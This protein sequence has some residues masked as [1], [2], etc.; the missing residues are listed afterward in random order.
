[1]R[2]CMR[3]CEKVFII[4]P[5]EVSSGNGFTPIRGAGLPRSGVGGTM[6]ALMKKLMGIFLLLTGAL[7]GLHAQPAGPSPLVNPRAA[8]RTVPGG[9]IVAEGRAADALE[10]GFSATAASIYR[11]LLVTPDL[12]TETRR[13]TTLAL[14]SALMESGELTEAEKILQSYDGPR[15]A[16]YQLRAGL[17]A[18]N[19]RRIPQAK[20][21]LAAGRA[22]DLVAADRGWWYFLQ[23]LVAEAEG[24]FTRRDRAY[25]EANKAAVSDL[26]RV[27]FQISQEATLLR[28]GPATE[29]MLASMRSNMEKFPGQRTGYDA[30]RHYAAALA[31]LNRKSE[32]L[33][34]LQRQ[35]AALPFTERGVA[36]QTRLMI[37]LIAG[38]GTPSGSKALNE[39]VAGGSRPETQRIALALLAR[40]A[41]T[42]A[43]REQLRRDLSELIGG[44]LAHPI[45]EDLRLARAQAA[46][47]DQ[48]YAPAEEDARTL[49]E[50]FPGSPLKAAALGVRLTVAWELKR[51]R[52]AADVIVQLRTALQ[53]GRE[54][55]ELGV[56]LAE[57]FFR[58]E[59]YKNAA[60]TYDAALRE[61]PQV[62]PAGVLIFQRVLSDIR[63]G[64]LDAAASLLD[65]T[66]SNATFDATNRWQ[67]EWNLVKEMQVRG[68]TS[69]AYARVNRLLGSGAQGV[70]DEL[71]VRLMWLRARLSF[72]SGEPDATHRQVDELLAL[73]LDGAKNLETGLRSDIAG[74]A[75]LL[76]AQALLA[77]NRDQEGATLL[78][79]LRADYKGTKAAIYSYIVQAGGLTQ[80]G[81]IVKAQELL[82]KLVDEHTQT[83]FAPLALYQLA[84]NSERLGLDRNLRDA[85]TF[86]ERL[87]RD[88]PRDDLVFHARLKQGDL[89]RKLNDF[90]AART[91]YESLVNNFA[92]HPDV[93]LAHLALADTLFAQGA[94]SVVN[95]ESAA[96]IFERLRDLPSATVD[97][98]AEAGFKWGYALAKRAQASS[99][100]T[101]RE[102]QT[103]KAQVVY[104]SVI[105][106]FLQDR[107]QAAKLG[108]KGRYWVARALLELGQLHEEAGRLDEAQRAYQLIVDNRLG[109][110]AQAQ[111]KL[112]RFRAAKEVK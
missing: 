6:R 45:I 93:L 88:Y 72:D 71:R 51:Y 26:Q 77:R 89:L 42:P 102:Q 53:P 92:Q 82:V 43:G 109:G 17:L 106:A 4:A 2:Q 90:G 34:V 30:T 101:E 10:A 105:D 7:A 8:E 78:E 39:L 46:L 68:Q 94:N 32:A 96:A 84:L 99:I 85:Y 76:K 50:R 12:A 110:A 20:A 29:Q 63:A 13:R 70:P 52:T 38:E 35:M 74:T 14:V 1:M 40:G 91:F 66:A 80:R 67:A 23:A 31:T 108:A 54:R 58:S 33:T 87:V 48:Q 11:E 19:S 112:A 5:P 56:L 41:K 25:E 62:V 61:S 64:Q 22:E 16:A 57:A 65:E 98:R 81:D 83:E 21:A 28:A 97:L 47:A 111:A 49:L 59:D 79:K 104:W 69:V 37:G 75:L 86:L 24:D 103:A 15:N 100:P 107:T 9:W 36:D 55:A 18:E 73:L 3:W 27:R 95:Y 44:P 60:D